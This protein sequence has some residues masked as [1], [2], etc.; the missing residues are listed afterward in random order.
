[1][2]IV[3]VISGLSDGGAEAVL[4]RLCSANESN[5]HTV[6]SLSSEGK[7]GALLREKGIQVHWLNMPLGRLRLAALVEL[8]RLLRDIKP[9]VVQT[10]MYHADLVGGVIARMA[11]IKYVSWGIHNSSLK[12]G[13]SRW[14]TIVVAYT[15]AFLSRFIP[16][17]IICCA[18]Q[19]KIV[20]QQ[21]GFTADKFAVIPNGY[22]I[23]LF[24]P[25]PEA[26]Q[27]L[28]IELGIDENI[29]LFGLV[30][31][32]DPQ[33][34]HFNLIQALALVKQQGKSFRCVLVGRGL[35]ANNNQ[36]MTWLK[37]CDLLEEVLLL[38]QRNDIPVVMNAIDMHIL[39][40]AYG[41]AFPNVICEAMACGTPC[42]TTDVGDAAFIV[43]DTGWVASPSNPN[44]LAEVIQ[45]ALVAF[46]DK[47][48]WKLR[49]VAARNRI[50]EHFSLEKMAAAYQSTW[51][52]I[53]HRITPPN[54]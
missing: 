54:N 27:K 46:S 29:P 32:F 22:N 42:I 52:K 36:V 30:G 13:K 26:G 7:Y 31:R 1:M 48:G 23:N 9:D 14:S 24:K 49:C 39:S 20:H 45:S 15:N 34:D 51:K 35:D 19:A 5:E 3:H 37:Q 17:T 4:Y 21:I 44:M 12:V 25:D 33:K 50:V 11:R 43:G 47:D 53:V 8:Y 6:I 38:G 10:W 40:S 18:D 41:E 16:T 2:K 28:R